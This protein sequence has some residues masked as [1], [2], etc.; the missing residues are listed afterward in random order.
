MAFDFVPTFTDLGPRTGAVR[1]FTIHMAE[2]GGTVGFL[3]KKNPRGVSVHYVIEHSGRVVRMLDE[4]HMH[5]SIRIG[6]NSSA[7]RL[8][9]DQ[10]GFF[11][12]SAAVAVLGDLADA[13]TSLGPNHS[14]LAV[15]IEGFAS[16]GPNDAQNDALVA[17]VAD[18]R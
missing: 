9:D 4:G 1:G 18:I 3:A 7:I 2:G 15:E 11:G 13:K 12:R 16:N 10:D 5:S 8:D 6:T 17:L 14:T